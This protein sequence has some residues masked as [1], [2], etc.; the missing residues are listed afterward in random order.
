[1]GDGMMAAMLLAQ[2]ADPANCEIPSSLPWY[3]S[4]AM[5]ALWAAMVGG[6]VVLVVWMLGARAE[7]RRAER[8]RRRVTDSTDST[9]VARRS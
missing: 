4:V 9:E 2:C 7:H 5:F 6:I 8:A 1:M 3:F